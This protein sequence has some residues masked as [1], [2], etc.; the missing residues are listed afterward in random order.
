MKSP[1]YSGDKHERK[2]ID[3][4]GVRWVVMSHGIFRRDFEKL[5]AAFKGKHVDT[6]IDEAHWLKNVESV[7]YQYTGVMRQTAPR[8]VCRC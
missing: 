6:I 1:E 8:V 7:L 4:T 2:Q 3:P 5:Y